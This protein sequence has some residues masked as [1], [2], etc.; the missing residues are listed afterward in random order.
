MDVKE[1]NDG[2]TKSLF[3]SGN[4]IL[5]ALAVAPSTCTTEPAGKGSTWLPAKRGGSIHCG[6]SGSSYIFFNQCRC[7]LWDAGKIATLIHKRQRIDSAGMRIN[8]KMQMSRCGFRVSRIT[9]QT[10]N[11]TFFYRLSWLHQLRIKMSTVE[12][13]IFGSRVE[14][15]YFAAQI[16]LYSTANIARCNRYYRCAIG[17]ENINALVPARAIVAVGSQKAPNFWMIGSGHRKRK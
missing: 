5:N 1:D 2:A 8:S 10:N 3:P 7:R 16:V 15:N 6:R 13:V 4:W 9:N 11:V 17:V 12:R 14:K